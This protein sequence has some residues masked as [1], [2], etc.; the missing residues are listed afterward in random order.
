M[1][2]DRPAAIPFTSLPL[3]GEGLS[4]E[5]SAKGVRVGVYLKI[6]VMPETIASK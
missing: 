5:A 2:Q 4:P 6:S 1:V 3:E